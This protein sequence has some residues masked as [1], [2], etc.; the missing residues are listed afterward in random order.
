V[1]YNLAVGS[2][3]IMIRRDEASDSVDPVTIYYVQCQE[4]GCWV[5]FDTPHPSNPV[6]PVHGHHL[7]RHNI[8]QGAVTQLEAKQ[9]WTRQSPD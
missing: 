5:I 7:N 2:L 9:G 6:C 1:G 3:E 4:D 8:K